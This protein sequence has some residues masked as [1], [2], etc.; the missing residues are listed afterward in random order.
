MYPSSFFAFTVVENVD[1]MNAVDDGGPSR[2]FLSEVWKQLRGL[3]ISLNG[4]SV[5]L[6]NEHGVPNENVNIISQ[7]KADGMMTEAEYLVRSRCR[8]LGRFMFYC[9]AMSRRMPVTTGNKI[10]DSQN[11]ILA[12]HVLPEVYRYY[13]M[14]DIDPTSN[15]YPI[16]Q[17]V[18]DVVTIKFPT[19]SQMQSDDD[20]MQT[21]VDNIADSDES[22]SDD[23][24]SRFR[25]LAKAD[26][27]EN[28]SW[29]VQ[30]IKE[31]LTLEG[32]PG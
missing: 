15:E 23:L 10:S 17:L 3:V 25:E 22:S 29:A 8:I 7:L 31:G 26:L 9:I 6:F 16:E 27:I 18:N 32:R 12:S 13:Y 2:A 1:D 20:R 28:R 19:K 5:E 11:L 14:K 4:R 24:R 21:Y 30:A